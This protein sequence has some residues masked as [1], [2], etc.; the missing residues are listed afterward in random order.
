[1]LIAL[2]DPGDPRLADY[3]NVPDPELIA[4]H[5]IF[6]AEGRL[7]VRRLLAGSRFQT[8][9]VMVTAP[10]LESLAG[11]I[12]PE[13]DVPI[14]L[15]TQALMNAV[16]GF[17]IHRGCLAIGVRADAKPWTAVTDGAR[18]VVVLER[19]S[20]A[21]NVGA[22]FRSAAAFGVDAVLLGP[23]CADPLYRKAIRTSM[24]AA[25]SVPFAH[26]SPWPDALDALG[27]R[28]FRLVSLTPQAG[29]VPLREIATA[30]GAAP[31]ALLLGHEGSG[32]TED[33][34]SRS[35]Y[36]AR[37]P[38]ADTVDSLNVATAAAI[39]MYEFRV[40]AETGHRD[41]EAQR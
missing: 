12:D 11:A 2:T 31:A 22:I 20:N 39:A 34:L 9:S 1:M 38:I 5:G 41:T 36:R 13:G 16:T 35:T 28:G 18:R 26:A 29:G 10:A 32:L 40:H 27:A 33:A 4:R 17:N 19:V 25:L 30:V 37:I 8:R 24:G 14:Y 7:V 6:V 3:R 21:D 15:V 23:A